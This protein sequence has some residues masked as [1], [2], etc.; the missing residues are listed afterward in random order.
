MGELGFRRIG[1]C[2]GAVDNQ[3]NAEPSGDWRFLRR[4]ELYELS[5]TLY[6]DVP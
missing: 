6:C 5:C 2:T 1:M 3:H 4:T